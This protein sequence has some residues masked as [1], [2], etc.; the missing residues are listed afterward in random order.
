MRIGITTFFAAL[1]SFTTPVL[2]ENAEAHI[3]LKD[4]VFTPAEVKVP[5]GKKITLT[6]TNQDSVAAEFES[7]DL[8]REKV[9][10]AGKDVTLTLTPLKPG[11]YKFLNDFH[12]ATSGTI[13]AE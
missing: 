11:S 6:I 5:A 4:Q 9:I 1:L 2:A 10:P 12:R 3:T 13:V 7:Y 8:S